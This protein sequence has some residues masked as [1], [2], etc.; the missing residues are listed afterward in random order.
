MI[1][2]FQKLLNDEKPLLDDGNGFYKTSKPSSPKQ[3]SQQGRYWQQPAKTS[4]N[5]KSRKQSENVADSVY[6]MED[7][8]SSYDG[9]IQSDNRNQK[10]GKWK[11]FVIPKRK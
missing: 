6:I 2:C 10:S 9:E 1:L 4:S 7:L 5:Q 11:N 3:K 8:S